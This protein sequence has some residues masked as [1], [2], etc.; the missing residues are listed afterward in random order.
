[1]PL[2]EVP[3]TSNG[4]PIVVNAVVQSL[5]AQGIKSSLAKAGLLF[6]QLCESSFKGIRDQGVFR[7]SGSKKLA[8]EL[9]MLFNTCK[10]ISH[11]TFFFLLLQ[12]QISDLALG[13][14]TDGR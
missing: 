4:V 2:A 13:C 11:Y 5:R 14:N 10:P 1:M 9:K 6:S 7:Q 8:N 12:L 3:K